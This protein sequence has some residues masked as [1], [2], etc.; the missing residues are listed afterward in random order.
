[1]PDKSE[2]YKN[3]L[4]KINFHCLYCP[5]IQIKDEENAT[6]WM[7]VNKESARAIIKKLKKEFNIK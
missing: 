1:M 5:T 7:D 6:K 2:Y 3:E 4:N